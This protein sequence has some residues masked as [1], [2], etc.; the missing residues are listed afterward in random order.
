MTVLICIG[1]F[2]GLST[3]G[4]KNDQTM[5]LTQKYFNQTAKIFNK[6]MKI[7][8]ANEEK[9]QVPE[10][11]FSEIKVDTGNIEMV[12]RSVH[13]WKYMKKQESCFDICLES[14]NTT[15]KSCHFVAISS[16]MDTYSRHAGSYAC[17]FGDFR[18]SG[19]HN[20]DIDMSFYVKKNGYGK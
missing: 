7:I 5:N 20:N 14:S 18:N 1:F 15:G 19:G 6:V 17:G 3:G 8:E 12:E 2:L 4:A 13:T 9:N 11:M 10:M 16:K